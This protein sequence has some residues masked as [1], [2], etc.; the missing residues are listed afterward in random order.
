MIFQDTLNTIHSSDTHQATIIKPETVKTTVIKPATGYNVVSTIPAKPIASAD[1]VV[2]KD[3]IPADLIYF[4]TYKSAQFENI[5]NYPQQ[6]HS[7]NYK[8]KPVFAYTD[9]THNFNTTKELNKLSKPLYH[10]FQGS[11]FDNTVLLLFILVLGMMAWVKVSFGKYLSQVF[12]AI[13]NYHDSAKLFRDHNSLIDRLYFI[14]N[15]I[16]T[17]TGGFF[18]Y[19]IFTLYS[20]S[21]FSLK[22]YS[23]L[24]SCFLSIF[25]IYIFKYITCNSLGIIFNKKEAFDEYLHISYLAFKV[26]GMLLLPIV[27]LITYLKGD[28]QKWLIYLGVFEFFT[29]YMISIFR[30]TRIMLQ[31]N[32]LFSYWILYLCTLEILPI[33]LVY[34]LITVLL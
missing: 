20:L 30:G 1:T 21:L 15:V 29:L 11:G 22:T 14:L 9:S 10:K 13:I 34:K 5:V 31:K 2:V 6:F 4:K 16:F 7:K 24:F 3:S 17:I 18:I 19:H 33:L 32:V 25:V 8:H 27:A 23:L 26:M 28:I 12:S